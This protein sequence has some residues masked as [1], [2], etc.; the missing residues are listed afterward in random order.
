MHNSVYLSGVDAFRAGFS[1]SS[2]PTTLTLLEKEEWLR[3]YCDA[4][5]MRWEWQDQ[6]QSILDSEIL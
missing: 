1:S 3:G 2:C 4:A 6:L 5:H